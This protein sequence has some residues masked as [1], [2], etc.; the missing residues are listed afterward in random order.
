LVGMPVTVKPTAP[1]VL[2]ARAI[3]RR[4]NPPT[5]E[6]SSVLTWGADEH[7]LFVFAGAWWLWSR[8]Q[9]VAQQR[10]AN[11]ILLTTAVTAALPHI[12]KRLFDQERP[13]RLTIRGHL[14]GVPFSGK[15]KD[16]FPS[17]HAI[18]IGALAS[19]ATGLPHAQRNTVWAVG[20]GLVLTRVVLLAH[21]ASDVLAGLFI[22]AFVERLLRP[23]FGYG[24]ERQTPVAASKRSRSP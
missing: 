9:S 8:G 15:A 12:L 10:T 4:T 6:I 1:D 22:G 13:D 24:S 11:H 14:R 3:A 18:H 2:I 17:G 16:A 21:W 23:V 19:A 20:A 5:E 7:V